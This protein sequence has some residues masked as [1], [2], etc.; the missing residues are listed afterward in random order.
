MQVIVKGRNTHVPPHLKELATH[1]L[2]KVE[3]FLER[4]LSLEIEF[5]EEH[6]PRI[7]D[8]HTVEVTLTTKAHVLRAHASGPDPASAVDAV[9]DKVEAQVKRLKSKF[10]RRGSRTS[11][12]MRVVTRPP[13]TIGE[14][15]GNHNARNG[16]NHPIESQ[17]LEVGEGDEPRITRVTRFTVKPMTAEEAVL[18]METLGHDF[19]LFVNAESEQAGVVYR[20]RDGS[21]GLIE[22][23]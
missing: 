4:I 12:A 9:L 22:P 5:S 23:D 20:R 16:R 7:A 6:N 19:Y 1:K 11:R 13:R 8:K 21:F 3:R 18:Q 10:V 15:T 2:E 17:G 14:E